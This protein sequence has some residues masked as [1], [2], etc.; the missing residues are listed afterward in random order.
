[1]RLKPIH[2]YTR[3]NPFASTVKIYV[4]H[5]GRKFQGKS[6]GNN[7]SSDRVRQYSAAKNV[8]CKFYVKVVYSDYE[9]RDI[10][11]HMNA[12]H[13]GH[14]HG[15]MT[16]CYF[17]PVHQSAISD[18]VEMLKTL[19]N[20]QSALSCSKRCEDILRKSA[21]LHE[22]KTFCFF[23]D[24]KEA[25][26]LSY[27]LQMQERCSEDGYEVVKLAVPKWI[28]KKK[29][30]CYQPYDLLNPNP[31]KRPLV[32][33]M[34]T[35]EMLKRRKSIT[36]DSAWVIDSTFKTNQWSMPLFIGMCPNAS[37]LG[38]PIFIML[39][40]DDNESGQVGTAL[41]LTI[42]AVFRSMDTI[43]PNAIVIDKDKTSRIAIM[44]GN[45]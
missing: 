13:N 9:G 1:M 19:N 37:G 8:G 24:P 18:C 4:C 28:Q 39:C 41:W 36:S 3:V 33:V 2:R 30:V 43:R 23:L 17:L 15:S 20:I 42:K 6:N 32:L 16:Y 35:E 44:R 12:Q 10:E 29:V 21:P 45:Q 34:Q 11:I 7:G 5:R 27:R 26:T 25:S 14:E 22:Q 40:N 38:M 31:N